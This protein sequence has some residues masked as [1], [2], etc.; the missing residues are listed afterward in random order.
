MEDLR[1]EVPAD[2]RKIL[3]QERPAFVHQRQAQTAEERNLLAALVG[4]HRHEPP[5]QVAEEAAALVRSGR[6]QHRDERA[7]RL[8]PASP[9]GVAGT[10]MLMLGVERRCLGIRDLTWFLGVRGVPF[11]E[12]RRLHEVNDRR[13]WHVQRRNLLRDRRDDGLPVADLCG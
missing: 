9:P 12:A 3:R 1:S 13:Q 2:E 4:L 5:L 8:L 10:S 7:L 6:D 11:L